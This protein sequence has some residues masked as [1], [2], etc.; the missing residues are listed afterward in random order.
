MLGRILVQHG[1]EI[2]QRDRFSD[3]VGGV[4]E[5]HPQIRRAEDPDGI[6]G[7]LQIVK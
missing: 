1:A 4:Y 5:D 3:Y 6:M 7:R 2:A